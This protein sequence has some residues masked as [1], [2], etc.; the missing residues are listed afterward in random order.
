MKRGFR[1]LWRSV[2]LLVG[3]L[4]VALAL[5]WLWL[6]RGS[7]D[8]EK[9]PRGYGST[10]QVVAAVG[11]G[12]LRLVDM[13][14]PLPA[15]VVET[16]GIEYGRVEP[17]V[18]QL[19]LYQPRDRGT[20]LVPGLLFLHGG[21]WRG[22]QREDY[23]VYTTWFAERG[24]VAATASYRLQ[25]AA[26]YPAALEDCKAAVRWMRANAAKIGV[27]PERIV[28]LGGS[29]GGHLAM[30]L[31]YTPD[32]PAFEGQSG[33]PGV[34]SRVAAVV[35]LYGPA[36][37]TTP[38]GQAA[39]VVWDFLGKKYDEDPELWRRASPLFH[40]KKGAPPTLV[41]HGTIDDTVPIDQGDSLVAKLREL[42]VPHE[43]HRLEGW[44]HT[45]DAARPM[46][47]FCRDQI[48][49]FLKKHLAKR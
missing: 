21:A 40:L 1:I 19:D 28:V 15:G 29:A 5:V 17:W 9:P 37:L 32:D 36:D 7:Y 13:T 3:A 45:L 14:P 8:G 6:H 12:A 35:D 27:D 10:K 18:L 26:K 31:G 30:M 46:N 42:G 16:K 34:S 4:A 22:G 24:F 47:E 23:R 2:T 49:R 38:F 48:E 39:S 20:N 11:V 25:Q 41:F 33:T 44:P 43:Y